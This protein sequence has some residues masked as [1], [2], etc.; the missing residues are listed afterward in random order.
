GAKRS[1]RYLSASCRA[2]ACALALLA[3][4]A[5]PS[6]ARNETR[7]TDQKADATT[8]VEAP[9]SP[10]GEGER[11]R[12]T[13]G[14]RPLLSL[15]RPEDGEPGPFIREHFLADPTSRDRTFDRFEWVFEELDG[16]FLEAGRALHWG[17]DVEGPV[18]SIDDLLAQVDPGAHLSDD[19]FQ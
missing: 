12:A 9:G 14:G 4:C 7:M 1:R 16:H 19:L 13:P 8:P 10:A 17:Q 15:W 3:A 11:A 18:A 2:S 6:R 5:A